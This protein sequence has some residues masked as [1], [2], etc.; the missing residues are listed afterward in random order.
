MR[1]AVQQLVCKVLH[2]VL[3]RAER[4]K[5]SSKLAVQQVVHKV[6]HKSL[7]RAEESVKVKVRLLAV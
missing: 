7:L 3:L 1:L 4:I 6:V 2:K 5:A